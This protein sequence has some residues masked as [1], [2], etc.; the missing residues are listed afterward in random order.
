[1]DN[2]KAIRVHRPGAVHLGRP[3]DAQRPGRIDRGLPARFATALLVSAQGPQ[4]D[5]ARLGELLL[6]HAGLLSVDHLVEEAQL[7][8]N[9]AGAGILVLV[10][11]VLPMAGVLVGQ[12]LQAIAESVDFVVIG[13]DDQTA[14][15]HRGNEFIRMEILAGRLELA[16]FPEV[17][18][19]DSRS[20]KRVCKT[21]VNG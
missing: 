4:V 17:L 10:E 15:I 18:I 21:K 6:R 7:E 2:A 13:A 5:A 20:K 16:A 8:E 12:A 1:V 11:E 9:V 3:R 14:G 19:A